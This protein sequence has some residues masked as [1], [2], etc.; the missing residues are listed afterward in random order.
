MDSEL[1]KRKYLCGDQ[2]TVADLAAATNIAYLEMCKQDLGPYPAVTKWFGAM[3]GR[4]SFA[5]TAPK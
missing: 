1:S 5:K 3:K 2:P 4:P